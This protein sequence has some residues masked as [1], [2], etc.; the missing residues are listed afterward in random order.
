MARYVKAEGTT[1]LLGDSGY[2]WVRNG[3]A[4]ERDVQGDQ[5]QSFM[6]ERR[7]RNAKDDTHT[8]GW[9]L[10]DDV[11]GGFFGEFCS[12][13]VTQAVDV[14]DNLIAAAERATQNS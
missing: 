5:G 7:T 2:A 14:A 9:Y 3:S 6:L 11:S 13:R 4:W 12:S 1:H 10:Y 8:T